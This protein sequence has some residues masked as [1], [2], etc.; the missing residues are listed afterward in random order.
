M[1]DCSSHY[2]FPNYPAKRQMRPEK[3]KTTMRKRRHKV[4]VF[5]VFSDGN[6]GIFLSCYKQLFSKRTMQLAKKIERQG[7]DPGATLN[8]IQFY[9][10]QSKLFNPKL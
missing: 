2:S 10:F 1:I 6:N 8:D 9:I 7:N 3:T 4:L 5:L